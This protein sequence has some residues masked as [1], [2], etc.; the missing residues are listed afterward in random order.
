MTNS[1]NINYTCHEDKIIP[2]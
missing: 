1:S 2:R